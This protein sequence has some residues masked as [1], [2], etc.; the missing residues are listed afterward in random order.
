MLSSAVLEFIFFLVLKV[1]SYVK[2]QFIPDFESDRWT[3]CDS[4]L[5]T[6]NIFYPHCP[7]NSISFQK[8]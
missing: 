7:R 3:R 8:L 2:R 4:Y 6:E 5:P 1:S